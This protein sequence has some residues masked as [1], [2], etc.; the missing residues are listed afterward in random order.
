MQLAKGREYLAGHQT[1]HPTHAG[2]RPGQDVKLSTAQ[3]RPQLHRVGIRKNRNRG[4]RRSPRW[5]R[6]P[7]FPEAPDAD[8]RAERSKGGSG[9]GL[10]FGL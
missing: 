6:G 10:L 8:F 4:T 3:S 2:V 5:T 7:A 9:P 1:E